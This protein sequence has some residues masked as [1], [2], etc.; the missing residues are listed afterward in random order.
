[1]AQRI[2]VN[3]SVGNPANPAAPRVTVGTEQR[4]LA[5][6][7]EGRLW[8]RIFPWLA[9]AV[10]LA[11][12][13]LLLFLPRGRSSTIPSAP[14]TPAAPASARTARPSPTRETTVTPRPAAQ[15]AAPQQVQISGFLDLV[16]H[17]AQ[18]QAVAALPPP[19]PARRPTPEE[20]DEA[21]ARWLE[22]QRD[23]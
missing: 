2:P 20:L 5:G 13:A 21:T 10:I 8:L 14:A 17:E 23:P 9:L 19:A 16:H 3:L 15:P 1:M 12:V 6:P 11:L 7:A 4:W 18:T 22:S